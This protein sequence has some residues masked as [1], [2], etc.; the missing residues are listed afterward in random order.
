MPLSTNGLWLVITENKLLFCVR[1]RWLQ[2]LLSLLDYLL[3]SPLL[4]LQLSLCQCNTPHQQERHMAY[5]HIRSYAS[6]YALATRKSILGAALS[7]ISC[8]LNSCLKVWIHSAWPFEAGCYVTT[9]VYMAFL[10][11]M[12]WNS[13][14][15]KGIPLSLTIWCGRPVHETKAL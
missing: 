6:F 9:V 3:E 15:V 1:C 13:S 2:P 4:I 5:I 11:P 7:V 10:L 12:H 8:S 14:E